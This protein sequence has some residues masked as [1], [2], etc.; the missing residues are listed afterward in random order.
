MNPKALH[1]RRHGLLLLLVVLLA[2]CGSIAE[3]SPTTTPEPPPTATPVPAPELLRRALEQRAVGDDTGAATLLSRLLDQHPDAAE[4]RAARYYL[5]ESFARRGRWSSALAGF[6]SVLEASEEDDYTP[7]AL[8]WLARS[9]EEVGDWASAAETYARYRERDTAI[10]PY[11]AIRQAA[12]L[13][14]LGQLA[15]AAEHFTHAAR[16]DINPGERAGSY[17]KAIALQQQ[18]GQP[19]AALELYRELLDFATI[20]HYRARILAEAAAL[21]ETLGQ[22]EQARTWQREIISSAPATPQAA[23]AAEQLRAAN[24]P[25]L[26]P[27]EA[28]QVLFANE[29][30]AAALPQFDA[31]LGT[32]PPD[33]PQAL[34]LRRLRALTIRALGDFG[35]ALDE[36]AQV[37]DTAAPGSDTALQARLDEIQTLGQSGEVAQAAQQYADYARTH[38]ENWRAPIAL[39]RAA[40]LYT[41]LG[42]TTAAAQHW[43]ELGQTHPQDDLAAPAFDQAAWLLYGS[44]N[45]TEAY[46]AWRHLAEHAEPTA[47]ARGAFW[48]ARMRAQANDP[49]QARSLFEHAVRAAPNSYYG[50]RAAEE[51]GLTQ[52]G[53]VPLGAPI[54]DDEWQRLAAWV[55][56]WKPAPTPQADAAAPPAPTDPQDALA[57]V[58]RSGTVQRAVGLG[59]VGLQVEAIA[60]WNNAIDTW[61][62]D[63]PRLLAV[64]RM[65]HQHRVPYIALRAAAR[66]ANLPPETASPTPAAL[67]RLMYPTPYAALIRDEAQ[68]QQIDPRLFYALLRQ[69]S[70]F[71]PGAT[72]WVG[73]RGLAQVM[74]AT[75]EGIAQ[76]LGVSNFALDDLYRPHVSIRF[77]AFYISQRISDMEGSIHGGLAAYNGGLGNALRW[78]DGSQVADPDLFAEYIDYP[79]TE[80]YV[81][82]VYAFYGVYR[83][84]YAQP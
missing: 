30:Y 72:S 32:L 55:S 13:R 2:A 76:N 68:Q 75:G 37:A 27:A 48:A 56:E 63:P 34:E 58:A 77:G 52:E 17:E 53:S 14:E 15:A 65:A 54:S 67:E 40:T 78:A 70:L 41:R 12:Q 64:A 8:F 74:P 25:V 47:Q 62:G 45:I 39:D 82:S 50:V 22:T 46:N 29:N 20:P 51:L 79:E 60:E 43:L 80:H 5:A 49:E 31:A 16:S 33:D 3:R 10:E 36:L 35:Q 44:G 9:Y 81:K 71:N 24:D 69:E 61:Q 42:D 84:I 73:A 1:W 11:A 28:A 21:A 6:R 38:A 83:R 57:E 4:T 26:T 23:A 7:L 19:A 18:L 59:A 66:L